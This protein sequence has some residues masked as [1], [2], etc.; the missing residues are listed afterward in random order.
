MNT[1]A[2]DV[3][4][5]DDVMLTLRLAHGRHGGKQEDVDRAR[6]GWIPDWPDAG[7]FRSLDVK[8]E[9]GWCHNAVLIAGFFH[10][11]RSKSLNTLVT[12]ISCSSERLAKA[13]VS[14]AHCCRR[15]RRLNTSP[16]RRIAV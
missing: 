6:D 11:K 15:T 10:G 8:D 14:T 7:L 13:G 3:G 16:F 5:D 9:A 4:D 1:Q 2:G 12:L